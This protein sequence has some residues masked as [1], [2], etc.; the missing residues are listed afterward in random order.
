MTAVQITPVDDPSRDYG[1][2][3]AAVEPGGVEPIP[4]DERHGSPLQLFWTWASPNLEFATVFVGVIGVLFFGLSFWLCALAIVIGTAGGAITQGILSTWGPKQGLPQMVL[5][6][7][8]FGFIGNLLPAGLMSITAGIG[9]FAVNSVS[10]ALAL[11]TLTHMSKVLSLV[12]IVGVQIAVAFFGHNLV[13]IFERFA[14]PLLAVVFVIASIEVL[15]KAHVGA[16]GGGGTPTFAAFLIEVAAA[17]G[18]AAGWNPY[19]SDYTRYLKPEVSSK[20]VALFAGLGI[21]VSCVALEIVG[22][23]SVTAVAHPSSNPTADF[24]SIM[25]TWIRDL[26]LLA[27]ALG[28]IAANVL[29]IYSGAMSFLAMGVKLPL[30]LRRAIVALVFGTIGFFVAWSG[31]HDSGA[32][33]E[34]FLLVISYWIAPWLG[35]VLTDRWLRRGTSI[36]RVLDDAEHRGAAEQAGVIAMVVGM[37]ISIWLF[38]NQTFLRGVLVTHHPGLGDLTFE[39]GFVLS[40]ALYYGLF[41]LSR[42]RPERT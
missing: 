31:L 9:W 41:K 13:Q 21:F 17:F 18:Y 19:A 12:I 27:I 39:V 34:N 16:H 26:T 10:G 38:A 2:K 23:A 33:Y 30:A 7:T 20:S 6:R 3:V 25:P 42:T 32:K 37:A 4:L 40:A 1:A 11:N 36:E 28:A 5:G 35:V 8:A 14:F 29:N 24:T 15:S 22:A